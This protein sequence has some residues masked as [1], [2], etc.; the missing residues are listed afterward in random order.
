M[1]PGLRFRFCDAFDR[2]FGWIVEDELRARTSHA[3]VGDG[4]VWLVDPL[5]WSEAEA[6]ALALGRPRGVVQLLDRHRRDCAG[7]ARRLG[8]PHLVLPTGRVAD[9]PFEAI[10]AVARPGWREVAL[11]WPDEQLLVVADAL[12]TLRHFTAP[13]ERLG[14]HPLLRLTPPRA[15]AGLEPRR[16]L[17]GHGEGIH[18]DAAAALTEALAMARRRLPAA[19][20]AGLASLVR[21]GSD[22]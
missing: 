2:G 1:T 6:R 19:W 3:L 15:L 7:V 13:G 10:A 14:V 11:W 17:C 18:T 16:I 20:L 9:S 22:R 8:I 4:G 12:G 5:A 21:R